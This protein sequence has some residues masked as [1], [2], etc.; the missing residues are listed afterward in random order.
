[1]LQANLLSVV[2]VAVLLLIGYCFRRI[3]FRNYDTFIRRTAFVVFLG[4]F[5]IYFIGFR[6]GSEALGTRLS[7]FASVFRPLLASVEMFAFGNGLIEVGEACKENMLYMTVFAVLHFAAVAVAFAVAINYL[8]VRF[9]SSW[10]WL[11]LRIRPSLPGDVH[12]FFG[13]NEV[14]LMLARDVRQAHAADTIIFVNAPEDVSGQGVLGF[15]SLFNVFSFRREIVAEV[16]KLQGIIRQIRVPIQHM[17]GSD[18]LRQ[19]RLT[20][21]LDKT[22]SSINFYLLYDDQLQNIAKN[23]KLRSDSYFGTHMT[24]KAYIYC[25][26]TSGKINGGT[27]FE[28]N[29][30]TG[31][32]TVLVD[33]AQLTA[34]AMITDTATHPVN[35]VDVDRRRGVATSAFHCMIIGFGETGQEI[36]KFLYEHSQF[37]YDDDFK[38]RHMVCHIVDPKADSKRGFFEM[39]YPC[40]QA[41]NGLSSLQAE[42]VW[43]NHNAGD[44]RFWQLMDSIRDELNYVVIATGSDNRNIAIAYDLCDYA[45]RWRTRRLYH[46]GIF[47]RSYCQI[48]ECRY[49]ELARLCVDQDGRQVVHPVGMLSSTFTHRYVWKRLLER[50]AAV[51]SDVYASSFT[52]HFDEIRLSDFDYAYDRWWARHATAK[53]DRV[54][55]ARI[56]RVEYQEYS[57]AFHVYTKMY[58]LGLTEPND[59]DGQRNLELLAACHSLH[60]LEQLPFFANLVRQEHYRYVASHECTGYTPMTIAEFEQEGCSQACD[61]I[62]HKLLNMVSWGE[63][64]ILPVVASASRMVPAEYSTRVNKYFLELLVQ[65]SLAIGLR[66]REQAI[67]AAAAKNGSQADT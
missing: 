5:V 32:E 47:V 52:K 16:D 27:A 62:R 4:G 45:L 9:K 23:I 37:A 34:K 17:P 35:F 36:F 56:K 10:R 60:D 53:G 11:R 55:Y 42:I 31:V 26:A 29:S 46:F 13:V 14:S 59:P 2:I 61:V 33:S 54:K 50:E 65:T 49:Q 30:V 48:N 41:G 67:A 3:I 51:F 20:R 24:A 15:A 22:R 63:L 1:M 6:D 39:R 64:P 66:L 38:G 28:Y 21:I 43:H 57:A 25:R 44:T 8:G 19:L 58:M 7:W 12:V 40:L 18:V